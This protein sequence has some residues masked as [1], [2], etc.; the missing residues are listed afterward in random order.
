MEEKSQNTTQPGLLC[1]FLFVWFVC[2]VVRFPC[3]LTV[4]AIWIPA[5]VVNNTDM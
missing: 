4:I 2:F 3:F 5:G 1:L